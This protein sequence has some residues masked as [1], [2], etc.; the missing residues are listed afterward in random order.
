VRP[1]WARLL[2]EMLKPL[3]YRSYHSGKWHVDGPRLQ[4]G[5]DRSYSLEDH[6]RHFS[7]RSHFEDDRKLAPAEPGSGY[8][9]SRAIAD[10]AIRC[11]QEHAEKFK[12]HPFFHYLCFT[13]PHFPLHALPDDMAR[14][15]DRYAKGWDAVREERWRRMKELGL[16]SCPLSPLEREVGPPYPFPEALAKLG[17]NEVNRPLP[18]PELTDAQRAFQAAKMAVH[19]AMIDRM[20][21]EIGRVL[22]QLKSMGALENTLVL[23]LSD[24]GASAEIMVRGDGHDPAAPPGSAA[25]FLCLGPGWSSAANTPLRRH[26]T[27]VHEGGIATPLIAHWPKGITAQGELRHN[28][29]HV[30]DLAP[31]LLELAGGTW[32]ATW[33]GRPVPPTPG[34]SLVPLFAKD[35]T[36]THDYLWWLHENN[37]AV[38]VGDWKLVAAGR[39]APWELYDLAADRGEMNNLAGQN[40][41]KARELEQV[42]SAAWEKIRA[43]ALENAPPR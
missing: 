8:Y 17:S 16:V 3:G 27:W 20:D 9:T 39:E 18:W 21:R 43:L 30:I 41:G 4:G 13:S 34:R 38:R 33:D 25:T 11:L 7:P 1:P 22:E 37:R 31:T 24:N 42:W 23:F 19:A 35:N 26:K 12:D 14:Y 2:P 29:G 40:P 5:F 32:P 6:D 10:H 36:V 15:R 28:P